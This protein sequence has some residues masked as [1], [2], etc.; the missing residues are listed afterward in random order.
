MSVQLMVLG[1]F[2][3]ILSIAE[4]QNVTF[5]KLLANWSICFVGQGRYCMTKQSFSLV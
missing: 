1:F 5:K 2:G 4:R 3:A